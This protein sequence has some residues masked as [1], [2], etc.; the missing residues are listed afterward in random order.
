MTTKKICLDCGKQFETKIQIN[1]GVDDAAS[2]VCEDCLR[3]LKRRFWNSMRL[4]MN[5]NKS[6]IT[7]Q[8]K[9]NKD[10]GNE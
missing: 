6:S 9:K 1:E 2:V 10:S 5:H 7:T 8:D 3:L 4:K